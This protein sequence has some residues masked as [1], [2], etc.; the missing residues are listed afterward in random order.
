[1]TLDELQS[2]PL[3]ELTTAQ[4]ALVAAKITPLRQGQTRRAMEMPP[5][6]QQDAAVLYKV[7]RTSIIRARKVLA[8]ASAETMQA[9]MNG[10]MPL[11]EAERKLPS[12]PPRVPRKQQKEEQ[13]IARAQQRSSIWRHLGIALEELTSL[14]QPADVAVI[15]KATDRK[16]YIDRKVPA[17]LTWLQEFAKCLSSNS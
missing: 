1:M 7:N 2:K 3:A 16:G 10:E 8:G 13:R 9:V 4:R 14:P 15:A 17:A 11:R 6:T 5:L 12:T